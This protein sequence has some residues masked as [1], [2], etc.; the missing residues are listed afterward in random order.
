MKIHD[1]YPSQWLAA[2]DVEDCLTVTVKGL[3]FAEVGR[4]KEQKPVLW[5]EEVEKGLILNKTNWNNM[6]LIT[7]EADSDDWVGHQVQ[8]YSTKVQ[9]GSDEVD[10]VRIRMVKN[11]RRPVQPDSA[12]QPAGQTGRPAG[13]AGTDSQKSAAPNG[14]NP[15]AAAGESPYEA[16][17]NTE[18]EWRVFL[19]AAAYATGTDD[20]AAVGKIEDAIKTLYGA[21][22]KPLKTKFLTVDAMDAVLKHLREE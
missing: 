9:F 2:A 5:F 13:G 10:A 14:G 6:V 20:D 19:K 12:S 11:V 21:A 15:G 7:K 1:V 8:L 3:T 22:Y 18:A 17:R 16:V 4:D